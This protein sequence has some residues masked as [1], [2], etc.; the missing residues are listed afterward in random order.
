MVFKMCPEKPCS[1]AGEFQC[2]P[3]PISF[4]TKLVNIILKYFHFNFFSFPS[5]RVIDAEFIF[6]SNHQ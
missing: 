5:L 1:S 2:F 6:G 3:K 4:V